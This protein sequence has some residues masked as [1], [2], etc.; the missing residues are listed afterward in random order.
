MYPYVCTN[1]PRPAL[2][3]E[4]SSYDVVKRPTVAGLHVHRVLVREKAVKSLLGQ[5]GIDISAWR[6]KNE[7]NGLQRNDAVAISTEFGSG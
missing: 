3:V 1:S 7:R 5:G 2:V 4:D 6:D